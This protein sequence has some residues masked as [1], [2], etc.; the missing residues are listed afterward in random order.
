MGPNVVEAYIFGSVK[1]KPILVNNGY[2]LHGA[3]VHRGFDSPIYY[4]H[5]ENYEKREKERVTC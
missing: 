4:V 2:H 5:Y 3:Y 1:W